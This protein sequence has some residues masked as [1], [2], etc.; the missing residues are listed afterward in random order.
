M[1]VAARNT[2]SAEKGNTKR[3]TVMLQAQLKCLK[4]C[5]ASTKI[6]YELITCGSDTFRQAKPVGEINPH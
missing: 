5:F 2:I 4:I 3:G 1:C 6:F